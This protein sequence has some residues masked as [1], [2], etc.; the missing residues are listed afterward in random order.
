M[1]S[2]ADC[3]AR[4]FK[5]QEPSA[6]RKQNK[7]VC[8]NEAFSANAVVIAGMVNVDRYIWCVCVCGKGGGGQK[9]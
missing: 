9:L 1:Q 4:C 2:F 5:K 6:I 3:F 8:R 7:T